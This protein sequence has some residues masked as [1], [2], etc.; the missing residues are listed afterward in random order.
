MG[1]GC[2]VLLAVLVSVALAPVAVWLFLWAA[3]TVGEPSWA[4]TDNQLVSVVD[5]VGAPPGFQVTLG[6]PVLSGGGGGFGEEQVRSNGSSTVLAWG[7]S[8]EG[9]LGDQ[10]GSGNAATPVPVPLPAGTLVTSIAAGDDFALA[11]TSTGS[12]LAWGDGEWGELGDGAGDR[13]RVPGRG[14]PAARNGGDCDRRRL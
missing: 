5:E 8:E 4:Y 9:A 2:W 1:W 10:A 6:G 3:F 14:G 12:V 7:F 13:E 11:L